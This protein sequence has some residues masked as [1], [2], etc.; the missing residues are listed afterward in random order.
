MSHQEEAQYEAQ[1]AELELKAGG[2]FAVPTPNGHKKRWQRKQELV[3]REIA[4]ASDP[5]EKQRLE[6][7]LDELKRQEL[8]LAEKLVARHTNA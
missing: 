5:Q 3:C 7:H 2:V 1:L 6:R 4:A 8:L